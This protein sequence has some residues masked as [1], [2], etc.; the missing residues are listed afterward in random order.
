MKDNEYLFVG[1][2]LDGLRISIPETMA[3]WK[4]L[5]LKVMHVCEKKDTPRYIAQRWAVDNG[6]YRRVYVPEGQSSADTFDML[7]NNYLKIR[8]DPDGTR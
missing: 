2:P 8:N 4:P 1:G 5:D 3:V 7:L 6:T